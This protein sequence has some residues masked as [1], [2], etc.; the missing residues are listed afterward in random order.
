MRRRM[1]EETKNKLQST[2]LR[3]RNRR[4]RKKVG[5]EEEDVHE[6]TINREGKTR[7]HN[8]QLFCRKRERCNRRKKRMRRKE[9]MS[10]DGRDELV[11]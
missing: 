1:T 2:K 9:K 7:E 4:E 8:N 5:E 11:I 3:K 6:T 10:E